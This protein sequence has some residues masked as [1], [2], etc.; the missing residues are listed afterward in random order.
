MLLLNLTMQ[1]DFN[2]PHYLFL[3][4]IPILTLIGILSA[5]EPID[6]SYQD[7]YI[8]IEHQHLLG[9]ISVFFGLLGFSYWKLI[10]TEAIR[11]NWLTHAHVGI[12]LGG[13]ALICICSLFFIPVDSHSQSE[14]F[15][16]NIQL[17]FLVNVLIVIIL[18]GQFIFVRTLFKGLKNTFHKSD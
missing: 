4:F 12:T 15:V 8:V 18:L 7:L 9:L 14:D 2:K 1:I 5:N 6:I 16:H 13:V 3:I 11:V 17:Q 10:S